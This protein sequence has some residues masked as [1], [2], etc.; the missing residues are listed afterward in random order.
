MS[1]KNSKPGSSLQVPPHLARLGLGNPVTAFGD[2]FPKV[3]LENWEATVLGT[4]ELYLL[5]FIEEIT[6]KPGW[7]KKVFDDAIVA[8]WR[9]EA[10]AAN[11][12]TIVGYDHGTLEGPLFDYVSDGKSRTCQ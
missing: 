7:N 5:A 6:N 1:G 8:K 3:V 4:R 10:K 2:G 9:A 11:W 12:K